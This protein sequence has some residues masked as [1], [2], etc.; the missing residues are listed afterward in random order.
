MSSNF[1]QVPK[2]S[3][4][5]KFNHFDLTEQVNQALYSDMICTTLCE[6]TERKNQ[7]TF[8]ETL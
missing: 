4:T 6:P 5:P 8:L 2:S 7:D 3:F 1:S